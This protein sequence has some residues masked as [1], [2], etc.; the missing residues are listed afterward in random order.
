MKEILLMNKVKEEFACAQN[1]VLPPSKSI[2]ETLT[3]SLICYDFHTFAVD[4]ELMMMSVV[5]HRHL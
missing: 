3:T 4:D 1:F 2:K 5:N